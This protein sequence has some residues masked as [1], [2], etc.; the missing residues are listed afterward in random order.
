MR[1]DKSDRIGTLLAWS[2]SIRL[3]IFLNASPVAQ[4]EQEGVTAGVLFLVPEG[5]LRV[6][7]RS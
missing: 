7:G 6:L 5:V 4:A 1:S 2:A 3:G